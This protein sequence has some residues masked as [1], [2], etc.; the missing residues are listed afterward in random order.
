MAAHQRKRSP[1]I[2]EHKTNVKRRI[3]AA[4]RDAERLDPCDPASCLDCGLLTSLGALYP[5][6]RCKECEGFYRE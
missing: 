6:G 2:S 3:A 1:W 5:S 4:E